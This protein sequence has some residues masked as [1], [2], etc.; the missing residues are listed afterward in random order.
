MSF[1]MIYY[2]VPE[3]N[4]NSEELNAF[5][6]NKAITEIKVSD[7]RKDFPL[8]GKYHFRFK[9]MIN[10]AIVWMDLNSDDCAA[11]MFQNKIIVKATRISWERE[12]HGGQS[13][14]TIRQSEVPPPQPTQASFNLFDFHPQSKPAPAKE[15]TFDLLFQDF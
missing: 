15:Q 5:G 1:T 11:L 3:D 2:F 7:I 10:K 13:S 9:N 6:I 8:V 4:E 14:T 12:G